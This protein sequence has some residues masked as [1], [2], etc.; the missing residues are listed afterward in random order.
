MLCIQQ[1]LIN[2]G[3]ASINEIADLFERVFQI[4][5]GDYYRTYLELRSRKT[6]QLKFLDHLKTSLAQRIY[7]ADA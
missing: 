5:L 3:N 2:S 1:E 7:E 6:N 4:E